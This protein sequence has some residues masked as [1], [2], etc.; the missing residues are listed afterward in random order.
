MMLQPILPPTPSKTRVSASQVPLPL[1]VYRRTSAAICGQMGSF[2][3]SLE[4]NGNL[5]LRASAD[6]HAVSAGGFLSIMEK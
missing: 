5:Q 1:P 2:D 4:S 3:G 6:R